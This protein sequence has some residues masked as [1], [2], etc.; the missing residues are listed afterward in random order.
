M[1]EITPALQSNGFKP[2]K[3]CYW[4]LNTQKM[5]ATKC[6][7]VPI[8]HRAVS[9]FPSVRNWLNVP[10]FGLYS[11]RWV[12]AWKRVVRF[13]EKSKEKASTEMSLFSCQ[14]ALRSH[15]HPWS[16]AEHVM[17]NCQGWHPSQTGA[18]W[19]RTV[20]VLLFPRVFQAAS[21][22]LKGFHTIAP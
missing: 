10:G 5:I 3:S 7:P 16:D 13:R 9:M 6:H 14:L 19:A 21:S 2:T 17:W 8:I 18:S 12:K 22:S 11:R 20:Q 4:I 1:T 15:W